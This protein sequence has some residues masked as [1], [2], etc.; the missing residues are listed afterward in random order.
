MLCFCIV[1]GPL[2]R[3]LSSLLVAAP[4]AFAQ[5]RC[6]ERWK[7]SLP[8]SLERLEGLAVCRSGRALHDL[9]HVC[10]RACYAHDLHN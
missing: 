1:W 6:P 10:V 3:T 5:A 8:E 4:A 9:A 2:G 7:S